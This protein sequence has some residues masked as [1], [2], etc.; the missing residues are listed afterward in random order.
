MESNIAYQIDTDEISVQ[1]MRFTI[2]N[3]RPRYSTKDI[4]KIRAEI[5][6]KLFEVFQ[7][8]EQT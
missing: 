3:R 2:I 6:R 7:K 1:K 5:E 4:D 8:Y